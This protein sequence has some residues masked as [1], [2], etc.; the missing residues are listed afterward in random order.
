MG[1]FCLLFI[2][3]R[4][5]NND[6]KKSLRL[7]HIKNQLFTRMVKSAVILIETVAVQNLH[8]SFCCVP[9]KDTLWHFHLLGGLGKQF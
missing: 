8:V 1:D 6:V 2:N 9:K 3:L 4:F 5:T 7:S